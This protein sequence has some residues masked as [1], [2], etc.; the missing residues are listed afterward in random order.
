MKF[1]KNNII[2]IGFMGT[3]KSSVGRYLARKLGRKV[4]ELDHLIEKHEHK[5]ISKIFKENG[6]PYFRRIERKMLKKVLPLKNRV[7][8]TGG[9]IVLNPLNVKDL[10]KVGVLVCLTASL[11]EIKARTSKNSQRPLLLGKKASQPLEN[12][13]RYRRPLY[14]KAGDLFVDTTR[15]S[16]CETAKEIIRKL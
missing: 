11:N 16:A 13:L 4:I 6:E 15:K 14:K 12:C 10:K 1:K 8:S 2:L 9:G 7:I 5:T 3:G